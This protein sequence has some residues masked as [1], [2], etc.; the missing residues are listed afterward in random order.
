MI[1]TID[2]QPKALLPGSTIFLIITIIIPIMEMK[3][4]KPPAQVAIAKGAS[5]KSVI[6]SI[7]YLNS[8]QVDQSVV[9]ASSSIF[10]YGRYLVLKPSKLNKHIYHRLLLVS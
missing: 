9:L 1:Q 3:A 8:F 10:L 6:P 5:E 4:V 7:E 2:A